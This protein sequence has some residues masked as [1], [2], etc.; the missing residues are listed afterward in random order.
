MNQIDLLFYDNFFKMYNITFFLTGGACRTRVN[1]HLAVRYT[2]LSQAEESL[3]IDYMSNDFGCYNTECKSPSPK[4]TTSIDELLS[5][6]SPVFKSSPIPE[7]ENKAPQYV[8]DV[9]QTFLKCSR[10]NVIKVKNANHELH[11]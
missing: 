11:L 2:T 7:Q 4:P 5:T 10:F 3:Q 8:G 1:K 9:V 6:L